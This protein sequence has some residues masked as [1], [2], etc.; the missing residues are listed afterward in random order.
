MRRLLVTASVVPSSPILGTLM[1]QALS[2]SET[3]VLTRATWHDIPED[4]ILHETDYCLTE[5][6]LLHTTEQQIHLSSKGGCDKTVILHLN[7]LCIYHYFPEDIPS[8]IS[9]QWMASINSCSLIKTGAIL[10]LVAHLQ[11][12]GFGGGILIFSQHRL[13]VS[14]SPT[15]NMDKTWPITQLH[16][17]MQNGD[18]PKWVNPQTLKISVL[19]HIT[20]CIMK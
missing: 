4:T 15:S 17:Y 19:S 13:L 8:I 7:P 12:L 1:K 14:N 5:H 11:D 18:I 20:T 6:L 10:F 9:L 3:S 16:T 2:S